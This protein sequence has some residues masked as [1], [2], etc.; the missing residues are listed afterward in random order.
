MP[1]EL[2]VEEVEWQSPETV[3]SA[4]RGRSG[5]A[6]LRSGLFDSAQARYSILAID[7]FLKFSSYGTR[8][9]CESA[10]GNRTLYGN[11]WQILDSLM[12]RY[13]LLDEIDLPFPLGGCLGVWGYDLKNFVEPG[14]PCTALNDLE[15]PDCQ[16]GFHDSLL[17]FDHRLQKLWIVST[18]MQSDGSR[19]ARLAAAARDFWVEILGSETVI[20]PP[21]ASIIAGIAEPV[22]TF[23]RSGFMSA[24][25]RAKEYIRSGD[26]YQV[27]LAQRLSVPTINS[28]WSLFE[29]LFEISPAPFSAY[30][31][32]GDWE[33]VSSSPELFL[34]MSGNAVQTR[35]IKGTRPRS[36]DPLRDA[37]FSY[38]LQTSQK[39]QAELVMIT[40]LLRN[41]LGQICEYGS[42]QVPD[43]MRLEKFPHV[44][45]LVSTVDGR[46]RSGL[47]HTSALARCFPGGSITGAPKIRAMQIIDEIEP[48]TRGPY[49]GTHGI[50][51]FNRESRL[52]ISIRSAVV[53]PETTSF[54]A[55]AGIVADSDPEM[56]YEETLAKAR[57]FLE[58]LNCADSASLP[59]EH[60]RPGSHQ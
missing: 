15:L 9:K 53:T 55:G 21:L 27:N 56:E 14:L 11:P 36:P 49:T 30:F 20:D 43:L 60:D 4:L 16:L 10:D 23:T 2:I 13:E 18:G 48:V 33:F 1:A 25:R 50:L 3:A 12:S 40:D 58:T 59:V 5:L 54:H 8:C 26:I 46:L 57:G 19:S 39:E 17:V 7:P 32:F 29:R 37:Q 41:D 34:K 22:S 35:P 28:G 45:H 44:Q 47:T 6:L 52:S 38:E 31:D 42:V 24:V 51:G